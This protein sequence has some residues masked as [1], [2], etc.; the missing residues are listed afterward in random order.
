MVAYSLGAMNEA[1][2]LPRAVAQVGLL[3]LALAACHRPAPPPSETSTASTSAIAPPLPSATV[4]ASTPVPPTWRW[5]R[6]A[7]LTGPELGAAFGD[8]V[9]WA[10]DELLI[11]A[12]ADTVARA[13][14]VHVVV[15]REGAWVLDR[16]L[17]APD[18]FAG[19]AFGTVIAAK[20]DVAV[21]GAPRDRG[22]GAAYV[23]VRREGKLAFAQKLVREGAPPYFGRSVALGG[24]R[25]M[26]G[27]NGG[28]RS[29]GA[30]YVYEQVGEEWKLE[31]K[32]DPPDDNGAEAGSIDFGFA[33]AVDDQRAV[34]T[35]LYTEDYI[36]PGAVYAFSRVG[37]RWA[38]AQKLLPAKREQGDV[39]GAALALAG[40][41][42][43][44]GESGGTHVYA[45]RQGRWGE[46]SMLA[47]PMPKVG[48]LNS[49]AMARPIAVAVEGDRALAGAGTFFVRH[50]G[51]FA[52]VKELSTPPAALRSR[53]PSLALHGDRVAIGRPREGG[54]GV[55]EV[56][57]LRST[58]P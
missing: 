56:W 8:A 3:A 49:D 29:P 13:G 10:G 35:S 15:R 27:A 58:R 41:T 37:D 18:G 22:A 4:S 43:L 12:P 19:N 14:A 55:V 1:S 44:V 23:L 38:F 51:V 57:V 48:P 24:Q 52:A 39:F 46:T 20:G 45:W 40:D 25:I 47:A 26:V 7:I 36:S 50:E 9:A 34:V 5:E 6:E 54:R 11:G 17:V 28:Y 16:K 53:A 2:V 33:V 42:L 32:L 31:G 30:A 21:V